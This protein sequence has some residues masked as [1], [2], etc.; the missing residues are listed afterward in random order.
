MKTKRILLL[1]LL[2]VSFSFIN[3]SGGG[4]DNINDDTNNDINISDNANNDSCVEALYTTSSSGVKVYKCDDYF[5]TYTNN[6]KVT[7]TD[8]ECG[9]HNGKTLHTGPKGG[10]YY[11]NSSG[12]K[13]YVDRSECSG[14]H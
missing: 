3:C 12:N 5:Y 9:T 2:T 1:L 14:C 8:W 11:I 10:C 4:D 6:A 7:V 13:S